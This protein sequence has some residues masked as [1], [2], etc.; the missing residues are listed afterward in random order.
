VSSPAP[1]GELV[2]ASAEIQPDT[3]AA[4]RH[5]AFVEGR[6]LEREGAAL[7]AWG[8][9]ARIELPLGLDDPTGVASVQERLASIRPLLPS[10]GAPGYAAPGGPVA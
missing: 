3:V 5:Y 2:W 6:V 9:A 8:V 7:F 4:A 1:P 10:A